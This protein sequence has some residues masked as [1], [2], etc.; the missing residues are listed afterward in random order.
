VGVRAAFG[1]NWVDVFPYRAPSPEL[2]NSNAFQLVLVDR[3]DVRP[4]D[5]D[6]WFNYDYMQWEAGEASLGSIE[7]C[8]GTSA[9]VGWSNGLTDAFELPGSAINGAFLDSGTCVGAPGANALALHGYGSTTPGR[10]V[11]GVRNGRPEPAVPEPATLI[12]LGTGLVGLALRLRR[13]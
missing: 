9:R 5:F 11:F 4:G 7:G 2:L 10:Y 1:V 12:M 13:R 8:G 6:I 3:S